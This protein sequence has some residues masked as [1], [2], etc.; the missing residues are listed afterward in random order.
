[1]TGVVAAA[2]ARPE[3]HRDAGI[4]QLRDG[5]DVSDWRDNR[6]LDTMASVFAQDEIVLEPERWKL[7]LGAKDINL[8]LA[9]G[10]EQSVPMP[11]ASL[12][13]DRFLASVAQGRGDMDWT[14]IALNAAADA[15]LTD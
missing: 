3:S 1:M 12:L 11:M 7:T 5:R 9:A 4:P 8:A 10:A 2:P 14:S 13:R 15:G 6:R